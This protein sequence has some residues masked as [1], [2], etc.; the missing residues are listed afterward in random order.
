MSETKASERMASLYSDWRRKQRL[1]KSLHQRLSDSEADQCR[2][3]ADLLDEH[4]FEDVAQI[5]RDLVDE[6]DRTIRALYRV[7]YIDGTASPVFY[8]LHD[9]QQHSA[10]RPGTHVITY[11]ESVS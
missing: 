1:A 4:H 10:E 6:R 2:V 5:L 9:A 11:K 8:T 3:A 7:Q